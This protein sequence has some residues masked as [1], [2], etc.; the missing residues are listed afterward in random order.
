MNSDYVVDEGSHNNGGNIPK[1]NENM[2]D[3]NNETKNNEHNERRSN[4]DEDS[5]YN[6]ENMNNNS[7]DQNV[8]AM[9]THVNGLQLPKDA[10][11]TRRRKINS[12]T[13]PYQNK[14]VSNGIS[15]RNMLS[16]KK[17]TN[18]QFNKNMNSNQIHSSPIRFNYVSQAILCDACGTSVSWINIVDRCKILYVMKNILKHS[19]ARK[20]F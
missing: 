9:T 18:Y 19:K 10:I 16:L 11:I 6:D 5:P 7:N 12:M 2:N 15:K 14:R 3:N 1:N 4:N 13:K 20:Q 8:T 17:K